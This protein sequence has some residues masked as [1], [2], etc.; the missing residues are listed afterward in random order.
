MLEDIILR[1]DIFNLI[2][3]MADLYFR[4]FS[5]F[6]DLFDNAEIDIV[7]HRTPVGRE[8]EKLLKI[9]IGKEPLF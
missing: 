4:L 8:L 7:E 2:P 5:S 3:R 1:L 9:P 6:Q